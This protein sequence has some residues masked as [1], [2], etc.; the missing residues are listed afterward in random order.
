MGGGGGER[1]DVGASELCGW[2]ACA[3]VLVKREAKE[4][5]GPRLKGQ[6]KVEVVQQTAAARRKGGSPLTFSLRVSVGER[7]KYTDSKTTDYISVRR[8]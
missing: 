7:K 2:Q 8:L 1:I 6:V 5:N 4:S 3:R